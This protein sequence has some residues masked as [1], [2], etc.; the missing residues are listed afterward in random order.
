MSDSQDNLILTIRLI[1]SFHY[2][3]LKNLVIK[4]VNKNLSIKE[5]KELVN[6]EIKKSSVPPPF[7]TFTYDTLKIEHIPFKAKSNDPVIN[8]EDDDLLILKDEQI[9]GESPHIVNETEISY[10]LMKDYLEYKTNKYVTITSSNIQ[11]DSDILE[12]PTKKIK[13]LSYLNTP[14]SILSQTCQTK[15][16]RLMFTEYL[17]EIDKP[18]NFQLDT[19]AFWL[20]YKDNW[21][22]LAAFA[23]YI[24]NVPA[25]SASVERIF[26]VGG[27]I[28]RPSRRCITDKVFEQLILLKSSPADFTEIGF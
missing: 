4:N 18:C 6:Q 11:T 22:E 15:N 27:A 12:R 24:L 20:K 21:G 13:L 9:L 16:L 23:N 3:N 28:L 1:R 2:R 8:C 5:F 14:A 7:K 17:C 10:F 19:S 25:T 26:S